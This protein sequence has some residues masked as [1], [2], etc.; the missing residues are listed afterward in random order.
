MK[1]VIA[2]SL[3]LLSTAALAKGNDL[4]CNITNAK[5]VVKQ[6]H[7]K[8]QTTCEKRKGTWVVAAA[9]T[10]AAAPKAAPAAASPA[11]ATTK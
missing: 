7:A 1:S 10:A 5:G 4:N 9:P 2:I 8:S 6:V 3:V 11:A